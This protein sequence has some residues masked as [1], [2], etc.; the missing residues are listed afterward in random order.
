[1]TD[2]HYAPAAVHPRKNSATHRTR[3]WV[4]PST[5]LEVLRTENSLTCTGDSVVYI[6]EAWFAVRLFVA[7]EP[8]IYL[9]NT[10][11]HY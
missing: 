8:K 3:G 10:V 2:E 5:G 7:T 9:R 11:K 1:M 6:K 4:V